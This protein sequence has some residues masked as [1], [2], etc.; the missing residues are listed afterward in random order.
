VN[1]HKILPIFKDA[2]NWWVALAIQCIVH[3]YR[4]II[5]IINK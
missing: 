5:N 3:M 2:V 1:I 4:K